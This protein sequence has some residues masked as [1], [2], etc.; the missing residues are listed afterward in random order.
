[1]TAN[2]YQIILEHL[3]LNENHIRNLT[4]RGFGES[5]IEHFGYK[6]WPFQRSQLIQKVLEEIPNP[7]GIPGFYKDDDQWKLAGSSGMIVPVRNM[8]GT[9]ASLKIRSDSAEAF[10]KYLTLSSKP[11]KDKKE[12]VLKYKHGTA[13]NISVHYPLLNQKK[14]KE[15]LVITEGELKAD[16][17]CY[18]MPDWYCISLPGVAMWEWALDAVQ[19][20]Q[21]KKILL[22][23]DADKNKE[24][25]TSTT[26]QK[27]TFIVAKSL[28]R[29]YLTLKDRGFD[30]D[31]LDWDEKFGKG[32]DDVIN[33]G[34]SDKIKT[35]SGQ[36][37]NSFCKDSLK[38]V[39]P[40]GWVYVVGTQRFVH[41]EKNQFLTKDQYSDMFAPFCPKGRAADKV[42]KEAA[43]TR[44]D[45]P[46]YMPGQLKIFDKDGFRYLNLWDDPGIVP[47]EG[48]VSIFTEHVNYI[49][50][51]ESDASILLDYLAF[52]IQYPTELRMW[53]ILLQ[54]I[55]GIGKSYFCFTMRH[56]LGKKNVSTPS[57]SELKERFNPWMKNTQMT[58]IHEIM[59]LGR[60]EVMNK[61]KEL[62]TESPVRIEDKGEKIYDQPNFSN[63]FFLTNHKD[64]IQ[65]SP[66][67]RRFCILF[68]PAQPRVDAYYEKLF[69][70]T[71][72]HKSELLHYLLY[73]DISKF[74]KLK[75]APDTKARKEL[76][77][78]TMTDIEMWLKECINDKAKP[79]N[80]DL[81]C[82]RDLIQHVPKY[83]KGVTPRT[84]TNYFKKMGILML[85]QFR[86]GNERIRL[87]AVRNAN[88]WSEKE[89]KEVAQHYHL[90]RFNALH[91]QSMDSDSQP[92]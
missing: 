74:K 87:W 30:V 26:P 84:L 90:T 89:P 60:K 10:G 33:G 5:A 59:T 14:A 17:T 70:W 45:Y 68:S 52:N 67:E 75:R 12:N 92:M 55:E 38:G 49:L 79:F 11:Q 82:V 36:E 62:I 46:V 4:H 83:V 37:A 1:M 51:E 31:I 91:G 16:F 48:D 54:G 50:P 73:R 63:F 8:D 56:L 3:N 64:A 28:S 40:V 43:L 88:I 66:T 47:K 34:F 19:T 24:C 86:V 58:F 65:I 32:I 57:D 22:A 39:I 20:I 2:P 78:N 13:A 69:T 42:L 29:L 80:N 6:T 18:Q 7:E 72:Q 77:L 9:I 44:L 23:F 53:S 81:V 25:S 76:L 41:I 71:E 85:G 35:M 61:V 27:D 15:V 21:P